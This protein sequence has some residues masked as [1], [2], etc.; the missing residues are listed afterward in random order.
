MSSIQSFSIDHI[1]QI[2]AI[3]L[4]CNPFPWSQKILE[5]CFG[6]RY[7][8]RGVTDGNLWFGFY[9]ADYVID[10]MTLMEIAVHPDWQRIGY[11]A[12]LLEDLFAQAEQ[13]NINQVFLEVRASNIAAQ[14]LYINHGFEQIDRRVGYYP[15]ATGHEDAII[16]R[17]TMNELVLAK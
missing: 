9:V 8:T 11:G 5:G 16:M 14:L 13:L 12:A 4:A 10:E 15:A 17:K 1:N 3:E 6:P 7:L 2:Y